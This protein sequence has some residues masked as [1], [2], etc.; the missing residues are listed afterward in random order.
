MWLTIFDGKTLGFMAFVEECS[1]RGHLRHFPREWMTDR[2]GPR[3]DRLDHDL[4]RLNFTTIDQ[5]E[6]LTRPGP[7][8]RRIQSV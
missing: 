8:A 2:R 1:E 4:Q 3:A 5:T 7:K 6:D